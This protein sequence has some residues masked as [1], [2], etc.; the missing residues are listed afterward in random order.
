MQAYRGLRDKYKSQVN[1]FLKQRQDIALREPRTI[2]FTLMTLVI[3]ISYRLRKRP[4]IRIRKRNAVL[5]AERS[6]ITEAFCL[7]FLMTQLHFAVLPLSSSNNQVGIVI[8]VLRMF[9]C[10]W[11]VII[12]FQTFLNIIY[13]IVRHCGN[14]T[15]RPIFTFFKTLDSDGRNGPGAKLVT[16]MFFIGHCTLPVIVL[17]YYYFFPFPLEEVETVEAFGH[18]PLDTG[19]C[20]LFVLPMVLCLLAD[21]VLIGLLIYAIFWRSATLTPRQDQHA[22]SRSLGFVVLT[23]CFNVHMVI[24][25]LQWSSLWRVMNYAFVIS[26]CLLSVCLFVFYCL[27][28]AEMR[29]HMAR[30]MPGFGWLK[31]FPDTVE[32]RSPAIQMTDADE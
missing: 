19:S 21:L 10:L 16:R 23:L 32:L 27:L 12:G 15:H 1:L 22:R 24:G 5:A 8:Q 4:L 18:V 31:N 30:H 13:K 3:Y 29:M 20:V 6:R 7:I 14:T 11:T 17:L 9:L 25:F 28:R 26:N 2:A